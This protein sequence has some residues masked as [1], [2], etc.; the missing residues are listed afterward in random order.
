[1]EAPSDLVAGLRRLEEDLLRPAIRRSRAELEE[2]LAPD[3]VEFGRSGRT[4]DRPAIVAALAAE[5]GDVQP[6]VR[7]EDF[8]V[9]LLAPDVALA[10]YR[11]VLEDAGG[12]EPLVALRSS[13]WRRDGDG[14]RM[15]FHQGTPSR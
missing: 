11:S 4:Y 14:W 13:I 10:T 8:L 15:T 12:G 2:R 3:F 7:I 6:S 5:V 1:M 9:R